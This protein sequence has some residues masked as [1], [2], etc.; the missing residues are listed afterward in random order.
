LD[1]AFDDA[2]I[3]VEKCGAIISGY[4]RAVERQQDRVRQV[5]GDRLNNTLFALTG[6][7]TV[8]MPLQLMAGI[9]GM[10]FVDREGVPTIPELLWPR[11]YYW[12][13]VCAFG[14]LFISC[15]AAAYLWKRIENKKKDGTV[16]ETLMAAP[17]GVMGRTVGPPSARISQRRAGI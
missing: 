15:F 2:S 10:N 11:G 17:L 7:T 3:L 8:L 5:A 1:E 14:Y 12:F 6:I 9:Y 16:P 4:E 13:L